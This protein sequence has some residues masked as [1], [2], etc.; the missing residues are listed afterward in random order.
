MTPDAASGAF[1]YDVSA[2]DKLKYTAK[3]QADGGVHEASKQ[4]EAM[5]IKQMLSAMRKAIPKSHL[6]GDSSA[7]KQYQDMMDA[8]WSQTMAQR[9]MGL[10]KML[11]KQLT[12]HAAPSGARIDSQAAAA[13]PKIAQA[14]PRALA[15]SESLASIKAQREAAAQAAKSAAA[16]ANSDSAPLIAEPPNAG[17]PL[18][19]LADTPTDSDPVTPGHVRDFV[20]RLE[21]PAQLAAR[22]TGLSPRLILAQAALETGWGRHEITTDSGAQSFNVFNIKAD[23]WN[24]PSTDV[25]TH[26]YAD[27]AMQSTKAGFRVYDSYNQA[28]SDY[29]RLIDSSPRYAAARQAATPEAAAR[30]L[31]NGGYATDPGYADKLVAVMNSIPASQPGGLFAEGGTPVVDMTSNSGPLV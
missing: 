25:T 13:A 11:D 10:A 31:Q 18:L 2:I 26:E 19:A 6:L 21:A 9:G 30:A 22:R 27:G 5:F 7:D 16:T 8:Q 1:A 14:T 29:A 3:K 15:P 4:F 17:A 23:G 24:G 12:G 20:Q 28:F